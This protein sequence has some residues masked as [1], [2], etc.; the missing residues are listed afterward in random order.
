MHDERRDVIVIAFRGTKDPVDLITD[1]TFFSTAFAPRQER[2]ASSTSFLPLSLYSIHFS[3]FS[4]GAQSSLFYSLFTIPSLHPS[5]SNPLF[6]LLRVCDISHSHA[7]NSP[8]CDISPCK[9][10]S[11]FVILFPIFQPVSQYNVVV[12]K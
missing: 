1:I 7:P 4:L 12:H 6:S 11:I 8:S 10:R 5:Y 9:Y 3:S 2:F